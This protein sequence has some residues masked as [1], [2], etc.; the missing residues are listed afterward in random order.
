MRWCTALVR[1]AGCGA[2][3]PLPTRPTTTTTTTR[4]TALR[5]SGG[6]SPCAG[7]GRGG[8]GGGGGNSSGPMVDG[9]A[10]DLLGHKRGRDLKDA[11]FELPCDRDAALHVLAQPVDLVVLGLHHA[12]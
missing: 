11:S 10:C 8:R 3:L 9:V 4:N 12:T 6:T 5:K 1:V 7:R 2:T